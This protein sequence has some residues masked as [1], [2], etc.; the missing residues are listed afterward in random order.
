M[1]AT[2]S[3]V[4]PADSERKLFTLDE[5]NATLPLVRAIV[6]DV[7]VLAQE[8]VERR[9]RLASLKTGRKQESRSVYSDELAHVEQELEHD[10]ERLM[11][12]AQELLALGVELKDVMT[13]LVDF[14]ARKDGRIVYL[15]WKLDEPEVGHWHELD[16]GFAGRREIAEFAARES[17]AD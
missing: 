3:D 12:Y 11:E 17:S 5:A 10:R 7:V 15:C 1:S 16:A 6:I 4:I 2:P 9:R 14:P 8:V 13:G